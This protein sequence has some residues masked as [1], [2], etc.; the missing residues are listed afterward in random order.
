MAS[1]DQDLPVSMLR[2]RV[3]PE[4]TPYRIAGGKIRIGGVSY[5]LAAGI[6][7]P[8]GWVWTML[9]A[10][11]GSRGLP[12]IVAEVHTAHPAQPV[13]VLERR[14]AC[15]AAGN[16]AGATHVPRQRRKAAGQ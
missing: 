3:K 1:V 15:R 9:A 7:D 10:M 6:S 8:D 5:G 2:P 4:H 14:H 16:W 12:E 13:D 11:D